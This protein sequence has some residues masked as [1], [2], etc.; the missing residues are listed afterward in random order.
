MGVEEKSRISGE[1]SRGN[2][3]PVLPTHNI[4]EKALGNKQS[5]PPAVY[6]M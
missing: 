5:L 4:Q 2:N 6:V 1:V 3:S